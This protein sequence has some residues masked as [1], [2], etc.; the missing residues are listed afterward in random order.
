MR[1]RWSLRA[2]N[3]LRPQAK[4]NPAGRAKKESHP[5]WMVFL[6]LAPKR[7]ENGAVMNDS[8]VGY[9]NRE[10]LFPQKKS[11]PAGRDAG[12]TR[13]KHYSII[14]FLKYLPTSACM[15]MAASVSATG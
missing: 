8:P 15:R 3:G 7:D 9:Q 13:I 1:L 4:S 2:A 12:K 6:F 14:L 10:G 5:L 11:N